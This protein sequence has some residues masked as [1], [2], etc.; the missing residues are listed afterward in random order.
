MLLIHGMSYLTLILLTSFVIT[1]NKIPNTCSNLGSTSPSSS[2]DCTSVILTNNEYCCWVELMSRGISY[3]SCL[4]S[5]G[6]DEFSISQLEFSIKDTDS[7]VE[8][9]CSSAL[10]GISLLMNIFFIYLTVL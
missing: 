9:I 4:V 10:L 5:L 1:S 6:K 3:T 2:S 7:S 8:V